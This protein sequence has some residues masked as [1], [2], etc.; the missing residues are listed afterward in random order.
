MNSTSFLTL[1]VP[2]PDTGATGEIAKLYTYKLVTRFGG[3]TA[4]NGEGDWINPTTLEL[5]QER[6]TLITSYFEDDTIDLNAAE[7]M[8]VQFVH[9]MKRNGQDAVMYVLNGEAVIV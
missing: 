7:V 2:D 3:A 1:Y 9:D 4:V 6:V 5:E 8:A